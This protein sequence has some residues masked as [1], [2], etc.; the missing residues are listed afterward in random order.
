MVYDDE[1]LKNLEA[2]LSQAANDLQY[3]RPNL[4]QQPMGMTQRGDTVYGPGGPA[5]D[6]NTGLWGAMLNRENVNQN[7]GQQMRN[8]D[9][10]ALQQQI[11]MQNLRQLQQDL[12]V[13]Q[14]AAKVDPRFQSYKEMTGKVDMMGNPVFD[15]ATS[16]ARAGFSSQEEMAQAAK[17]AS[18]QQQKGAPQQP[19]SPIPDIG[20][21]PALD[22]IIMQAQPKSAQEFASL[23]DSTIMKWPDKT[24]AQIMRRVEGLKYLQKKQEEMMTPPPPAPP[25]GTPTGPTPFQTAAKERLDKSLGIMAQNE[26]QAPPVKQSGMIGRNLNAPGADRQDTV[27]RAASLAANIGNEAELRSELKAYGKFTNSEIEQI[28]AL[29]SRNPKR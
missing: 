14:Q 28:V 25:T 24:P 8:E 20:A 7:I 13:K 19:T 3:V 9:A 4:I 15:L 29:W 18:V 21:D 16:L 26:T 5:Q 27:T 23:A 11:Q 6:P 17:Q 22:Q 10:Q 1:Y 2:Q 12:N